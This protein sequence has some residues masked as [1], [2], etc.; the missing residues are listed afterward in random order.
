L[1][2]HTERE[3]K[4]TNCSKEKRGEKERQTL[5]TSCVAKAAGGAGQGKKRK[6]KDSEWLKHKDAGQNNPPNF[7]GNSD[8]TMLR[9]NVIFFWGKRRKNA[10]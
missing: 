5:N 1:I 8:S 2:F 10:Q 3:S 7:A 6:R 4:K 9:E